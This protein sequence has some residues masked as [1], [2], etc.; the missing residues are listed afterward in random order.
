MNDH[1]TPSDNRPCTCGLYG[2]SCNPPHL[3]HVR[4][5]LE[6][7]SRCRTLILVI[8]SGS[9]RE[10]IDVRVRYRWIYRLTS[11]LAHVKLFILEDDAGS[12]ESCV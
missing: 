9:R 7:A 4:C 11:H 10:E 2:G 5:S 6:A 8:S 3:G 1:L 12:K